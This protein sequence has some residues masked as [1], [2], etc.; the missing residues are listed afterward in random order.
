M[1][2]VFNVCLFVVNFCYVIVRKVFCKFVIMFFISDIFMY[3]LFNIF[4]L[5]EKKCF[6]FLFMY[7]YVLKRVWKVSWWI[8][9]FNMMDGE[10]ILNIVLDIIKKKI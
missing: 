7:G 1:L 3:V 5:C 8:L 9:R 2:F 10:R 4:K 6:Y